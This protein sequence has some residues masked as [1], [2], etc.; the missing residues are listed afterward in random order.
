MI[1]QPEFLERRPGELA[2]QAHERLRQMVDFLHQGFAVERLLADLPME[3]DVQIV[4]GG[5]HASS[6]LHD[7]SFVLSRYGDQAE[8]S[9]Y[10]GI[11]GPTRMEYPR[12]VALVRYMKDL[13]TD[14][15]QAY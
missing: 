3:Y 12:A 6:S 11:V 8:G 9:G 15:M 14:L 5:G 7:Y 1:Q 4:I 10:L 13:M 2:A